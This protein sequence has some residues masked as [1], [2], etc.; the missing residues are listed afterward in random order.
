M[1]RSSRGG[2]PP[3]NRTFH[4]LW[5]R[6]VHSHGDASFLVFQGEN[7]TTTYTYAEFDGIVARVAGALTAGG[8]GPGSSIH[9]ALRNCPAFVAIW[10]AA[11]RLGAW[12]VPVDP[13]STRRDLEAQIRRTRPTV[14]ICA[15]ARSAAYRQAAR[16]TVS[17][18]MELAETAADLRGD[19]VLVAHA[20]REPAAKVPEPGRRLAV[21]FTSGTTSAPKGVV[22]TQANYATAGLEMASAA[23]LRK[24]HRWL[25]TLPLFH[26]NAQYYCFAPAIAVGASVALTHAFSASRW[27]SQAQELSVTHASLFAAPIRMIL[28]RC[29]GTPPP[30]R[31]EHVWFAQSLG[32]SHYEQFAALVGCRPRQL[33][34]M[35]ETVAVV[36]T[37]RGE[38]ARHDVIGHPLPGREVKVTDTE[39]DEPVRDPSLPGVLWVRGVRGRDLFVGYLDDPATTA[40]CFVDLPDGTSWLRTGDLVTTAEGSGALRFAGRIDDVIKVSGEN[41]SLTE[42][43]AVIAQAPGV[44]EAAVVARPDPIRDQVP[45]AYVVPKD[46]ATPPSTDRL[47]EYAEA[48]LV[49]AARPREWHLIDELPRTSV[50]KVRRFRIKPGA[51]AR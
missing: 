20:P 23:G 44:L 2:D 33:Y 7:E 25:V 41:V 27:A 49:P 37:D 21:M 4:S 26:A 34:G 35:T 47:R 11:T 31:L 36:T 48:H 32:H 17:C 13:A 42:S 50:G 12:L 38:K 24:R 9:V 51:T 14:G 45:V 15:A 6:A 1:T 16:K 19:S 3:E 39:H 40:R 30:L 46:P 28:A 5:S 8:V 18:T 29:G 10:L 22:L 43:E